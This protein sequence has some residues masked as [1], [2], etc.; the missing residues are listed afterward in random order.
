MIASC[1]YTSVHKPIA[2]LAAEFLIGKTDL[3]LSEILGPDSAAELWALKS[4]VLQSGCGTHREVA[5]NIHGRQQAF[6]ITV[7]PIRDAQ[8]AIQGAVGVCVDTTALRKAEEPQR[9]TGRQKDEFLAMLA[10]EL[11]NPL[12]PIRGAVELLRLLGSPVPDQGLAIEIIDRQIDTLAR[13]VD[14]LL[15]MSR[16]AQGKITVRREPLDISVAIQRAVDVTLP[17]IQAR[18]QTLSVALAN[19]PLTVEGDATRLEQVFGN[20]L[21]N[22]AKFTPPAGRIEVACEGVAD[23]AVVS[24]RD[25]G[26]GLPAESIPHLFEP[27]YQVD[28]GLARCEGGLG[29]GLT[30]SKRLIE[31]HGGSIEARS[32]GLTRGSEFVVRL[33][34]AAAAP[35]APRGAPRP[36]APRRPAEGCGC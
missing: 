12:A 8:G 34:L 15:D 1:A 27:F 11:R 16:I 19:S 20:L 22:A 26:R 5:L 10:H 31:L 36:P 2:G 4:A 21:N 18:R 32:E 3:E 17:L 9:E 25:H 29:I 35:P 13:L 23:Q 14:D 33:P 30:L 24:I 6:D 7:E 28:Q